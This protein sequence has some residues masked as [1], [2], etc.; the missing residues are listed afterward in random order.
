MSKSM[1]K[2]IDGTRFLHAIFKN[3][4]NFTFKEIY[5]K[6]DVEKYRKMQNG[7]F[8][9]KEI[10]RRVWTNQSTVPGFYMR[11][12]KTKTLNFYLILIL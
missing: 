12:S 10:C 3:K 5:K 8:C 11:Y 7:K 4:N 6:R 1:D 2:A 9:K